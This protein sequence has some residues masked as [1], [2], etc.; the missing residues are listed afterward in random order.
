VSRVNSGY[1][2]AIVNTKE[3]GQTRALPA[4]ELM[5]LCAKMDI[6]LSLA[7]MFWC[8]YPTQNRMYS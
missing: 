2:A 3:T 1:R 4:T 8:D 7:S 5:D 6:L